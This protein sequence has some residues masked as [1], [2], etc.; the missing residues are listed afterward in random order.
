MKLGFVDRGGGDG[1]GGE[2]GGSY[3]LLFFFFLS[4]FFSS[5]LCTHTSASRLFHD[6]RS[7]R[8]ILVHE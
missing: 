1:V 6:S 4:F 8:V 5:N 2:G 7:K 3:S